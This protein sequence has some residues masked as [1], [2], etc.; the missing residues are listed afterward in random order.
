[1]SRASHN[2]YRV[3]HII[4]T[5]ELG[6]APAVVLDLLRHLKACQDLELRL[7]V[8][9]SANPFYAD[10]PMPTQVV[11]LDYGLALGHLADTCRC[12]RRLCRVIDQFTPDIVHTHLWLADMVGGLALIGRALPHVSHQHGSSSGLARRTY[13]AFLKRYLT[14]AVFSATGAFFIPV[15]VAVQE[16]IWSTF[17]MSNVPCRVIFNGVDT[18]HF[19]TADPPPAMLATDKILIGAA[20]RMVEGKGF[21][22]LIE[23]AGML[24]KHG[25]CFE[26]RLAG[27][28]PFQP[29][30][31]Q[32]SDY[33][34][35]SRQVS[36]LGSVKDMRDFYHPLHVF[37][38]PSEESE[39]LSICM[40]EAMAMGKALV[41]TR[42]GGTGEV[43]QTGVDGVV[44][45]P[46]EARA[47][48]DAIEALARNPSQ[49]HEMGVRARKKVQARFTVQRMAE[50]VAFVYRELAMGHSMASGEGLP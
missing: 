25:V 16:H 19:T 10:A 27:T 49:R 12:V 46:G 50:E 23:A 43:I 15:A 48:A 4:T 18:E 24:R 11:Y 20:G 42:T 3:L 45:P 40:L 21:D 5:L 9:G 37:V 22:K 2:P 34:G 29:R 26:L 32:Q 30:L 14:R 6:G 38:L 8:L 39:G 17:K 1:M 41:V 28:G 47:L 44:V 7:C 33:L 35:L 13:R 31:I 36:F